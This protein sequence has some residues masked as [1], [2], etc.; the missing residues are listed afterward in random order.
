[1]E[2]YNGDNH[3]GLGRLYLAQ[4]KFRDADSEMKKAA[5]IDPKND[6]YL[7][8]LGRVYAAQGDAG[9]AL[10]QYQ[11]AVAL[12]PNDGDNSTVLAFAQLQNRD[13]AKATD[14][15][16]QALDLYK[17]GASPA[18]IAQAQYGLGVSYVAQNL[19]ADAIP[20]LQEALRLNPNLSDAR[21]YLSACLRSAG[22]VKRPLPS[23]VTESSPL[24]EAG[25]LL[26]L[27]Q[28]LPALGVQGQA[29]YKTVSGQPVL[30]VLYAANA[31]PNDPAFAAEQ[32]PVVYAGSW[33]LARL[34]SPVE[35]LLVVAVD[36][37]GQQISSVLVRR[38]YA[39]WW[40]QHLIDD[41]GFA[42]LWK[43]TN[44]Q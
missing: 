16:K 36:A 6:Q 33:A 2:P 17:R 3:I 1:L 12:N 5:E 20:A 4:G 35:N 23:D 39:L 21:Q 24:G 22:L 38:E 26:L 14:N 29:G 41:D 25:A 9:K 34:V 28:T 37:N 27:N 40:T 30:L 43:V 19:C 32:S 10:E 44:Q 13:F 7:I 15:F 31:K 42:S 11:K 18:S 8:W